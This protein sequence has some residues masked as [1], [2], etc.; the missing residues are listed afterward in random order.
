M[1]AP[2]VSET[3]DPLE[4]QSMDDVREGVDAI[5]REL[6]ALLTRRQGYM[7]AAARIKPELSDVRVPWRIEEVVANVLAESSK[8]GLSERIA[9]PIWRLL[10]EK[11]IDHEHKT[12]LSLRKSADEKT[13]D[14]QHA[15]G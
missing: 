3:T 8:T 12:W 7:E 10:I 13:Q 6:V 1:A 2:T 9:E 11:C 14:K 4:C 5:D 15:I